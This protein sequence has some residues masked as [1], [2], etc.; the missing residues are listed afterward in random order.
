LQGGLVGRLVK[1]FG[2]ARVTR[3][4]FAA[5]GVSYGAL[6]LVKNVPELLGSAA[7]GTFGQG[8]LRPALTAQIT[9]HSGR[10]EQGLVL[11]IAQSLMSVAQITAPLLAGLLIDH[12][13]LAAWALLAGAAALV[14]LLLNLRQSALPER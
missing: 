10:D 12:Q 7:V 8:S 6:A 13:Q 3:A 11:G 2:E 1:R 14:G 9:H 4:G 5:I